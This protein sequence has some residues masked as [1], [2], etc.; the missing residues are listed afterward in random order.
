MK[1]KLHIMALFLAAVFVGGCSLGVSG[2]ANSMAMSSPTVTVIAPRPVM[3]LASN[4]PANAYDAKDARMPPAI[5][6]MAIAALPH[7][8]DNFIVQSDNV[9][10]NG[11]TTD[12][13][14]FSFAGAGGKSEARKTGMDGDFSGFAGAH[15]A[16]Y[17][18][19]TDNLGDNALGL[20]NHY[21]VNA[22]AGGT[23]FAVDVMVL[24]PAD[25][26]DTDWM[27][28]GM[29]ALYP[30]SQ[31]TTA[32]IGNGEELGAFVYADFWDHAANPLPATGAATYNGAAYFYTN[33][34]NGVGLLNVEG[35]MLRYVA[36]AR[37]DVSF[38][39]AGGADSYLTGVVN[40]L[41][42]VPT[43]APLGGDLG[44]N[45]GRTNWDAQ[46]KAF[47]GRDTVSAYCNVE[48]S[49]DGSSFNAAFAGSN[50]GG[51]QPKNLVGIFGIENLSIGTPGEFLGVNDLIGVFGAQK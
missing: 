49:V 33:F 22:Y 27:A 43:P 50:T 18:N 7:Y 8:G 1:D 51:N 47:V 2:P 4:P 16:H 32:V 34:N 21:W 38:A 40:N 25:G 13:L 5:S 39:G 36:D 17:S 42:S 31:E 12:R 30:H 45:I 37:F 44:F 10:E 9:N 29:W 20:D 23:L 15:T 28:M 14:H 48:C 11:E 19:K 46:K 35:D 26:E 3:G 6:G 24:P 41:T